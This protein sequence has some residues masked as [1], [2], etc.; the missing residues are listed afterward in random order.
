MRLGAI[1][2]EDW[3]N[4]ASR[5]LSIATKKQRDASQELEDAKKELGS[6]ERS[7]LM[8]CVLNCRR[9]VELVCRF[10]TVCVTCSILLR[11]PIN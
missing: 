11:T 5:L 6:F 1:D 9:Q 4:K 7:I 3:I 10:V 2:A 8:K